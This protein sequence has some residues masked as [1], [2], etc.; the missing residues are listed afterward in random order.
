MGQE[1]SIVVGCDDATDLAIILNSLNCLS[2]Y[3]FH[4]VSATRISDLLGIAKSL[5]P[6]LFILCF[7]SNQHVLNDF[8]SF[9]RK[10][11]IPILCLNP[12]PESE[13]MHWSSDSIVFSCQLQHISNAAYLESRIN[14]IFLLI[15]EP[16]DNRLTSLHSEKVYPQRSLGYQNDLNRYVMELDQKANVLSAVTKRITDICPDVDD[17]TRVALNSIVNSIR[18]S[19]NNTKLWEDFKL[20]FE[21][22]DP[23]FLLILAKKHPD[24]TVID[25]KYCCYLKMNMSNDDIRSL[26]GINQESVRTHKYRLKRKLEIPKDMDLGVYLKS[27]S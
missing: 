5:D 26:L 6:N 21:M 24:L 14:S 12:S 9:V 4:I 23:E 15:K 20:Y 10:P 8:H 22:T 13:P 2:A 17:K 3:S 19:S 7:R 27:V 1:K 25:L 18:M 16:D 11:L